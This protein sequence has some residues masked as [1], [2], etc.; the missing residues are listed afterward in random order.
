MSE[1]EPE[2]DYTNVSVPDEALPEDLQPGED[3]PLAEPADDDA[4]RPAVIWVHG[5]GWTSGDKAMPS[6]VSYSTELA[7]RGEH[8]TSSSVAGR[9]SQTIV[10]TSRGSISDTPKC[11]SS[12][13]RR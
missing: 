11:P 1:Q 3:N 10:P 9:R 5:G 4:L 7:R 13:P 2:S 12:R 6:A 8:S